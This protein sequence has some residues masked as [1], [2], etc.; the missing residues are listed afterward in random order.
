[1]APGMIFN[2]WLRHDGGVH[3]LSSI[4]SG[5][6][7]VLGV[8]AVFDGDAVGKIEGIIDAEGGQG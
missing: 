6:V 7:A 1:M 5:T 8:S 4:T 3:G 2:R